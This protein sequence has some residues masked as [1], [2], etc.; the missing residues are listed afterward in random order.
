MPP[1]AESSGSQHGTKRSAVRGPIVRG[2]V[3]LL[4]GAVVNV[5]VAWGCVF[6]FPPRE[7]NKRTLSTNE[8]VA[9][10]SNSFDGVPTTAAVTLGKMYHL[11]GSTW[12]DIALAG[13][14]EDRLRDLIVL[15][16]RGGWPFRSL[17]GHCIAESLRSGETKVRYW[18]C[19]RV[20]H[21]AK[22]PRLTPGEVRF[23]PLRPIWSGFAINTAFYGVILWL[24]FAAPFTFR[25]WRRV[26]KRLCVKCAYPVGSSDLCTECGH[27]V[28]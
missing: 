3:F 12:T 9:I 24:I 17:T 7:E 15:R 19:V 13:V 6:S 22:Y 16:N 28:R 8:S 27:P 25:R 20:S 26:R 11:F 5:A 1:M 2:V 23:I 10:L 18:Y 14:K 4:L 21:S